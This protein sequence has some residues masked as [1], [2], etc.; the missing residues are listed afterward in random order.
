MALI[1]EKGYD[2]V[3]VQDI[4]E[5][6]NLGRT[7]FYTH[8]R[9]KEDLLL[10]CHQDLGAI[11]A[12]FVSADLLSS[13]PLPRLATFLEELRQNRKMYYFITQSSSAAEI[14]L[15]CAD[16]AAKKRAR[17]LSMFWRTPLPGRRL[18]W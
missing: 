13:E 9:S 12:A 7:T 8:Y 2:A 1:A 11:S 14:R 4:T 15:V 5:R 18:R 10:S 6:A 17:Y 3:T 16:Y